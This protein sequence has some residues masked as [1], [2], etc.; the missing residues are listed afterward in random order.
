MGGT[1]Q[2][3]SHHASFALTIERMNKS[4][5]QFKQF[6]QCGHLR[7]DHDPSFQRCD[8]YDEGEVLPS[9]PEGQPYPPMPDCS[10]REFV[11]MRWTVAENSGNGIVIESPNRQHRKRVERPAKMPR[12]EFIGWLQPEMTL[13]D[14]TLYEILKPWL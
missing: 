3:N 9:V 6:C 10:C 5:K 1:I 14:A 2:G 12:Q 8:G 4:T 13:S 7:E 11:S